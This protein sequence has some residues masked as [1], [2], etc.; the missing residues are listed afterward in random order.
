MTDQ[1]HRCARCDRPMP[2]DTALICSPDAAMLRRQLQE[3]AA[4]AG[5]I[6]AVIGRRATITR[7]GAGRPDE[8]GWESHGMALEP[9]PPPLAL[10]ALL[11]RDAVVGEFSAWARVIAEQRGTEAPTATTAG[12][13]GTLAHWLAGQ[14]EWLRH[15]PVADEA[16]PALLDACGQARR[17][18]DRR[19]EGQLVGMCHCGLAVYSD[20]TG[21]CKRCGEAV[22]I[23]QTREQLL[24]AMQDRTVTASEAARWVATLGFVTDATRLRKLIWAWADR[25]HL[26]PVDDTP[27]Y[28]F[29]DVLRRVLDSPALL[30]AA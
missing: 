19:P 11:A 1:V 25:G 20:Q 14:V 4:V 3:V 29:G 15:Q 27:R 28:R 24:A 23:G 2:H 9:V 10:T 21:P 16:F 6:E 18:V 8:D 12:A 7:P 17:I 26:A 30:R 22:D 5:D 13:L